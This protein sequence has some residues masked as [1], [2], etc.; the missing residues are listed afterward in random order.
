LLCYLSLSSQPIPRTRLTDLFWTDK[1]EARGRGNLSR[2]LHNLS[3]LLPGSLETDRDHVQLDRAT[4]GLDA[5]A[6]EGLSARGDGESL[7][8]AVELYR[9]EFMLSVQL[10]DCPDF[11]IWLVTERERWHTRVASALECLVGYHTRNGEFQKGLLFASRLLAL[12]PWREEAHR[13]LMLLLSLTDQRTAA[14]AQ[15]DACQRILAQEL[16]VEPSI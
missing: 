1:S 10:D 13:Q 12:D 15:Y 5:S 11:E 6:F 8:E 4:F 7:T 14:L 9:G 2:V 3:H 16:G